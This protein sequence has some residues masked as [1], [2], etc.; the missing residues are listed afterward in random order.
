MKVIRLIR[1]NSRKRTDYLQEQPQDIIVCERFTDKKIKG[2]C[3]KPSKCLDPKKK[4]I[5]TIPFDEFYIKTG[6]E[7]SCKKGTP[8][9]AKKYIP[10]Y[11]CP[12]HC[13]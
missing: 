10:K 5:I 8:V 11:Y 3:G 9:S 1:T 7:N 12:C 4:H 13:S 2:S 6:K